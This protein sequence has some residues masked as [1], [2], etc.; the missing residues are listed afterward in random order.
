[1]SRR[2][3][4]RFPDYCD[5]PFSEA[6]PELRSDEFI[7]I[8]PN[9]L[10]NIYSLINLILNVL[11]EAKPRIIELT[12]NLI[13]NSLEKGRLEEY[14][15]LLDQVDTLRKALNEIFSLLDMQDSYSDWFWFYN[16]GGYLRYVHPYRDRNYVHYKY[17]ANDLIPNLNIALGVY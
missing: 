15:D 8:A 6:F 14:N 5:S 2:C 3:R 4:S 11:I 10:E 12:R 1:M 17:L 7:E 13:R 9:D 16:N